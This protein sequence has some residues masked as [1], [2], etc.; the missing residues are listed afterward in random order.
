MCIPKTH[1]SYKQLQ[2]IAGHMVNIKQKSENARLTTSKLDGVLRLF[3]QVNMYNTIP[4][5][6]VA[7][8]P[9]KKMV[10]PNHLYHIESIGGNWYLLGHCFFLFEMIT[11]D[12]RTRIF[13]PTRIDQMH[14]VWCNSVDHRFIAKTSIGNVVPLNFL[15]FKMRC[16]FF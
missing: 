1:V 10:M 7:I 3:V 8:M 14:H 6:T 2:T 13:L 9:K 5:P 4:L 11:I 15:P 12:Y 16:E